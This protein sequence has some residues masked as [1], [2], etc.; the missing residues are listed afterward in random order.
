MKPRVIPESGSTPPV[1]PDSARAEARAT[2]LEATAQTAEGADD[3][4]DVSG[5]LL[6]TREYGL[7]VIGLTLAAFF[8]L[9]NHVFLQ[10]DNLLGI[11]TAAAITAIY[12][13]GESLVVIGGAI[14]LSIAG[15]GVLAAV[16]AGKIVHGG[17]SVAVAILAALGVGIGIGAANAFIVN[18]LRV[19]PL[20]G[21]LATLSILT[22]VPLIMTDANPIFDIHGVGFLGSDKVIGVQTPIIIMVGLYVALAFFLTQTVWGLRLSA[23]GGNSESAR[24]LGLHPARYSWGAFIGCGLCSSIAGLVTLGEIST[25]EPVVS[26]DAVFDAITA[27]ALAGLLLS[28]GRGSLSKVFVAAVLLAMIQN[29]LIVLGV[30]PY[31]TYITTG[32]L[33][34]GA[35]WLNGVISRAIDRR[36]ETLDS[37]G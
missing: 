33:L 4:R 1:D 28:G 8:A 17:S 34:I 2:G 13:A 22:G 6:V 37:T 25:A 19:E 32:T 9:R 10:R 12:A 24:R 29:G 23:V 15:T 16:V 27:I 18:R 14:D 11:L 7:L 30:S 5:L 31:Y 35:V 3:Q 36:R 21:T 20:V 26:A